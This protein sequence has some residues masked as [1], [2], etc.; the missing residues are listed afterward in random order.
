MLRDKILLMHADVNFFS[1]YID[2]NFDNICWAETRSLS[3]GILCAS[4]NEESPG[5]CITSKS[6]VWLFSENGGYT[7]L[8]LVSGLWKCLWHYGRPTFFVYLN[9]HCLHQY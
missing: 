8:D 2:L 3:Q 9:E 4:V 1:F 6:W 5:S 7:K